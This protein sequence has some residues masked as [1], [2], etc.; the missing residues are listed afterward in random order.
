MSGNINYFIDYDC[1][2]ASFL[3]PS[4]LEKSCFV[5][6]SH[7]IGTNS[8]SRKLQSSGLHLRLPTANWIVLHHA[9]LEVLPNNRDLLKAKLQI[10]LPAQR[11]IAYQKM[12]HVETKLL[13][14]RTEVS[15][16]NFKHV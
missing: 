2:E 6:K 12:L 11:N 3:Q 13:Q 14:S 5:V 10:Q 9:N 8:D 16:I 4:L 15:G 1:E 7:V